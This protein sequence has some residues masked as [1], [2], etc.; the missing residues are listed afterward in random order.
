MVKLNKN[1]RGFS[2]LI[3]MSIL[4]LLTVLGITVLQ[5]VNADIEN[6]AN[7]KGAQTALAVAEAGLT[8]AMDYL[9]TSYALNTASATTFQNIINNVNGD[10]SAANTA[11]AEEK[12][13]CPTTMGSENICGANWRIVTHDRPSTEVNFGGGRYVVW[14]G[15]DPADASQKTLLLRSLGIDVRGSQRLLEIAVTAGTGQT[16]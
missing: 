8:Y 16:L 12:I 9:N 13:A 10:L 3:G 4:I 15:L 5:T 11:T 2:L 14:V 1:E 7:D 6:A